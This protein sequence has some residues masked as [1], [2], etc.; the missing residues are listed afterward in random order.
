M[1]LF[2]LNTGC[3]DPEVCSLRWEWELAIPQLD[4]SVFIIPG[5]F[6]KNGDERLVV[7]NR[8][9]GSVCSTS[10]QENAARDCHL[11]QSPAAREPNPSR[12]RRHHTGAIE[13]S[14][15][16]MMSWLATAH[17]P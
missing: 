13:H 10:D 5:A 4:T 8:I 2:T 15:W 3:R 17:F 1:A 16:I 6:V 7:L 11:R 14:Y 9:A 12:A